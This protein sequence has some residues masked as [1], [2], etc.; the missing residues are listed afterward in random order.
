MI[1]SN[2]LSDFFTASDIFVDDDTQ[3][4]SQFNRLF[5]LKGKYAKERLV[6]QNRIL[7]LDFI[8]KSNQYFR[9]Y[10]KNSDKMQ[11]ILSRL[12]ILSQIVNM[13][14]VYLGASGLLKFFPKSLSTF[15]Y[16]LTYIMNSGQNILSNY[17]DNVMFLPVQTAIID[18]L[19]KEYTNGNVGFNDLTSLYF[20]IK[21]NY[22]QKDSLDNRNILKLADFT[23]AKFLPE[24]LR[25][26][27]TS[28]RFLD[29]L[30]DLNG[31]FDIEDFKMLFLG[32]IG[33]YEDKKVS[34]FFLYTPLTVDDA[35]GTV[36]SDSLKNGINDGFITFIEGKLN[37]VT[38][39]LGE[40]FI[41]DIIDI[42]RDESSD[43]IEQA[44]VGT[45]LLPSLSTSIQ[46]IDNHVY[47]KTIENVIIG[48]ENIFLKLIEQLEIEDTLRT[49]PVDYLI[50]IKNNIE[51]R[52]NYKK[53]V[54]N[55]SN[56]YMKFFRDNLGQNIDELE[57]DKF[58]EKFEKVII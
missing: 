54:I 35:L 11:K 27:L 8:E 41:S 14:A 29:R 55:D 13:T 9:G 28:I 39:F 6:T 50:N 4:V 43:I 22:L 5:L 34:D 31:I 51:I 49:N 40:Q 21:N 38:P 16:S 23:L 17:K 15:I 42:V 46:V 48:I 47:N 58:Q 12:A 19:L 36:A 53:G 30:N 25:G 56:I 3:Q 32:F 52:N 24:S 1:N 44:F 7:D 33:E 57:L 10:D 26:I 20:N 37:G 45:S 2:I 18:D